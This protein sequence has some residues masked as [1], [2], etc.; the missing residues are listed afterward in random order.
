MSRQI[1]ILVKV[2]H[3][4]QDNL[5]PVLSGQESFMEFF[6]QALIGLY[7]IRPSLLVLACLVQC[8]GPRKCLANLEVI[9]VL[10]WGRSFECARVSFFL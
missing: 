5:S 6:P 8:D 2:L 7:K 3:M 10:A 9:I 1:R 4:P